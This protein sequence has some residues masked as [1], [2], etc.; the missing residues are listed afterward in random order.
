MSIIMVLN[1]NFLYF[2]HYDDFTACVWL[3]E[4]RIKTA[5]AHLFEK[6]F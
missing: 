5:L 3:Q 2:L 4:W 1:V 6:I